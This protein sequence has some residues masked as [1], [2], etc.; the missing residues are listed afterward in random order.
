MC[1]KKGARGV[2]R[3]VAHAEPIVV[4]AVRIIVAKAGENRAPPRT[5]WENKINIKKNQIAGGI[6]THKTLPGI[7]HACFQIAEM[8]MT[9]MTWERGPGP[10]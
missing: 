8:A 5:F 3:S 6:R 10:L 4:S 1:I 9:A 2:E 7:D